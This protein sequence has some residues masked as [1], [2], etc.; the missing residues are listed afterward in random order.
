MS[1]PKVFVNGKLAG[2]WAYGYSSF[3]VEITP[4]VNCG[5]TNT[6]AVRLENPA[7]SSRWYPGGGIYRHVWLEK[8]LPVHVAHWGV[9]V[10]T[11]RV[12]A[13]DAEVVVETTVDN[14][15]AAPA[16]ARVRQDL[17]ASD[18]RRVLASGAATLPSLAAGASGKTTI[19]MTVREPQLWDVR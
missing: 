19:R 16:A 6:V 13:A 10:H 15:S 9:F 7:G 8:T 12:S 3:R 14:Q 4:L 1:H 17:V 5:G 18:G 11:P 2:E